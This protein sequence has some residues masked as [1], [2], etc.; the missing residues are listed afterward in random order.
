M[1]VV[2]CGWVREE[3]RRAAWRKIEHGP[4]MGSQASQAGTRVVG[5]SEWQGKAAAA[6]RSAGAAAI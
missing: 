4:G 2:V 1:D 3:M 6:R 5:G